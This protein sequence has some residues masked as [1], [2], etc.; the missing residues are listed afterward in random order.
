MVDLA[1][2][3]TVTTDGSSAGFAPSNPSAV[4]DDDAGTQSVVGPFA[5]W[6]PG[7][8]TSIWEFDFGSV[9]SF[10]SVLC[11]AGSAGDFDPS[12]GTYDLTHIYREK[13]IHVSDDGV[14][15][16]EIASTESNLPYLGRNG[17][18]FD[19]AEQTH[20]Y[21]RVW[22]QRR[23][24][25]GALHYFAAEGVIGI[26][27]NSVGEPEPEPP[28][29]VLPPIQVE[30]DGV[31]FDGLKEKTIRVALNDAGSFHFVINRG[32]PQATEDKIVR[33]ALVEVT[34]P[35]IHSG[36]LAEFHLESG[37]FDL[38]KTGE[39]GDEWLSFG[40]PGSLAILKRAVMDYVQ[41]IGSTVEVFPAKGYWKFTNSAGN[42]T[43][44]DIIRR[45]VDEADEPTRPGEPVPPITRTFSDDDD[46]D[47]TPWEDEEFEGSWKV[48]IGANVYDEVIRLAN[49]GFVMV[50]MIPPAYTMNAYRDFG[51]D[52]TSDV[53]ATDKVR[54]V[55]GVNIVENLERSMLGAQWAT[56]AVVKYEE[57]YTRAAI[58]GTFPYEQ[59]AYIE[60]SADTET[61]ARREAQGKMR[62]REDAQEAILVS[63]L[64]PYVGQEREWVPTIDDKVRYLP[65]PEWS[66]NG[67]YWI[68]DLVTLHTGDGDFEYDNFDQRIYAITLSET[69][70][71][72]LAI[73][74]VELN[75]PYRRPG[76]D[77]QLSST[78]G[79]SAGTGNAGGGG[80]GGSTTVT[81][82]P[83]THPDLDW[84]PAVRAA[85]TADVTIATALNSGDTIDG[86]TLAIHDR[87]LVKDQSDAAE[88]GI[89]VV[90]TTPARS[91][92]FSDADEVLGAVVY[93]V[94]GTV[95]ASTAW[96][97]TNTSAPDVGTDDITFDAFGGG[98]G[99][100]TVDDGATS[101]ADVETI[102]FDGATVTDDGGGQVTVEVEGGV[103]GRTLLRQ[104]YTRTVGDYTTSGTSMQ[105]ID[106]TNLLFT[107]VLPEP[108]RVRMMQV[109]HILGSGTANQQIFMDLAVDGTRVG[110]TTDSEGL[111]AFR[112]A[113]DTTQRRYNGTIVYTTDVL[114]AGSHTFKFMWAAA[115]GT[116]TIVVTGKPRW[117]V[118]EVPATTG[119]TAIATPT[120]RA[121]YTAGDITCSA[122]AVWAELNSALRCTVPAVV[123]DVLDVSLSAVALGTE[124]VDLYLTAMSALSGTLTND[125]ATDA[126]KSDSTLGVSGWTILSGVAD[127]RSGSVQYVVQAGDISGGNVTLT[128]CYRTSSSTDRV[129]EA[130]ANS[131]IHFAVANLGQPGNASRLYLPSSTSPSLT[132]EGEVAYDSDDER[133]VVYDGQRNRAVSSV[134]WAPN[135]LQQGAYQ[136]MAI[137]SSTSIAAN[138][139][140]L[141]IPVLVQSHLLLE[142]VTIRQASTSLAREWGWDL[143][144]QDLNNGNGGENTLRRVAES[145]GNDAFTPGAASIRSL[146][147]TGAPVYLA[148]GVY[149]LAIQ[150]THATN[151]LALSHNT[152][153]SSIINTGQMKTTTNPNGA[154]LDAVAATWTKQNDLFFAALKGRVFGQTTAF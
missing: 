56:R 64:S 151:A 130:T 75:A 32:D 31:S 99:S 25:S 105:D 118:E 60:S 129:L 122:N 124:A 153:T 52:L 142:E 68:G 147:A 12:S 37:D 48:P 44:G 146:A 111:V 18:R 133:V 69:D 114:T 104:V 26:T 41:R 71:G 97:V 17:T 43:E 108:A 78:A 123:G 106:G 36:V 76:E 2:A 86:V 101:V 24:P 65:G 149:W 45:I 39:E 84:K 9:V 46:T 1:L 6:G 11:Y 98:G 141:L 112:N 131:P 128:P 134:G 143:Y 15:W 87:V 94:A 136:G 67:Q 132:Q 77:S 135:A 127:G 51:R 62:L 93:V 95:N 3:A 79:A 81:P 47:G 7:S 33:G 27:V 13:Q 55:K 20:R 14:A 144:V 140:T 150:C 152:G 74:I 89:Y 80:G 35:Q 138:G 28:P 120:A 103:G 16:T 100:L 154:T 148:P 110:G 10:D 72:E 53:F 66:D 70:T 40:G 125:V 23:V 117:V 96:S 145:N 109:C 119:S 73:P 22:F 83:H 113:N 30:I 4:N 38:L 61:T 116:A 91:A 82:A 107:L 21:M 58:S 19:F 57:T 42:R 5:T 54:F 92:D 90:G 137:S 59:E 102:V 88:N 85:T 63:V 50:E 115:S 34:I 49:G 126:A 29:P 8:R 121:K 139:G